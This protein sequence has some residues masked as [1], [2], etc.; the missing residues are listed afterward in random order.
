MKVIGMLQDSQITLQYMY[1][2]N[3]AIISIRLAIILMELYI[4]ICI[5][6]ETRVSV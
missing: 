1:S 3:Y 4:I 6:V 2:E 5:S